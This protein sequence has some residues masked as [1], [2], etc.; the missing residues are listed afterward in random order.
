M[1]NGKVYDPLIGQWM[2]P[3]WENVLDRALTPTHLHLYRFNGND[4][5]NVRNRERKKHPTGT[6]CY[7][8]FNLLIES[9]LNSI[10]V[11]DYIGWLSLLGYDLRSMAPQLF[12]NK[13]PDSLIPPSLKPMTSILG[14]RRRITNLGIQSGFLAHVAQRHSS[15]AAALSVPPRSALK[16]DMTNDLMVPSRLGSASEPTFGKGKTSPNIPSKLHSS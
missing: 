13:L 12:P 7:E 9:G 16:K 1:P 2:T 6:S 14:R 15:D 3:L 4:P 5:I 11:S 10:V 8:L